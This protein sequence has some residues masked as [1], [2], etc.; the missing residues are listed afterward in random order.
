MQEQ[1]RSEEFKNL[2]ARMVFRCVECLL[3]RCTESKTVGSNIKSST[4]MCHPALQGA[5]LVN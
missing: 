5:F 3:I 1:K 2:E 4:K